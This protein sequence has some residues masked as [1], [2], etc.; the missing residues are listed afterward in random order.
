MMDK[1]NVRGDIGEGIGGWKTRIRV[2]GRLE[3]KRARTV[4]RW[5][6]GMCTDGEHEDRTVL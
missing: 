6:R 1:K 3:N 2:G 5:R 4:G